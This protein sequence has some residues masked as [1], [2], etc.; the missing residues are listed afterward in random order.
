ME[1]S[2]TS[3]VATTSPRFSLVCRQPAGKYCSRNRRSATT[4]SARSS[5]TPKA[6]GSA[7]TVRFNSMD[8]GGGLPIHVVRK[9]GRAS[10]AIAMLP[11][12]IWLI[13]M[14]TVARVATALPID[15]RLHLLNGLTMFVFIIVLPLLITLITLNWIVRR[16]AGLFIT[17]LFFGMVSGGV[18]QGFTPLGT[19]GVVIVS[20]ALV[21][22]TLYL[23]SRPAVGRAVGDAYN[24]LSISDVFSTYFM[25]R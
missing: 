3:V 11:A 8:P 19:I 23:L 1:R 20:A 9:A 14:S 15:F 12:V 4:V 2:C 7:C 24:F 21:G 16:I 5:A 10:I 17:L 6:T 13:V 18:S 25:K 22:S